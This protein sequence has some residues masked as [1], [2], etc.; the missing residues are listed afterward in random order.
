MDNSGKNPKMIAF[1]FPHKKTNQPLQEFV[2]PVDKL[3]KMTNIDFFPSL[4]DPIENRLEA[5]SSIK[6]WKF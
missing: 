4:E 5:S 3:E 6:G 1:L 2:V